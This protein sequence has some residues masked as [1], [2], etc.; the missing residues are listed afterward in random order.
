[1]A[2]I[3]ALTETMEVLEGELSESKDVL[4]RNSLC[5]ND[6]ADAKLE[7]VQAELAIQREATDAANA[8]R[9]TAEM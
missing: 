4:Q 8:A 1:M 7:V 5:S 3:T 6:A 9:A 2:Q